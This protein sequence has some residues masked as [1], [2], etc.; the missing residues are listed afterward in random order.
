MCNQHL[1]SVTIMAKMVHGIVCTVS[2]CL[3]AYLNYKNLPIKIFLCPPLQPISE[4]IT[5]VEDIV[6]DYINVLVSFLPLVFFFLHA[7]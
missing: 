5:L 2:S 4:T 6:V 1:F 3:S 7:E